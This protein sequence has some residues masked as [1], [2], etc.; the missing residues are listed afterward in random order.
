MSEQQLLEHCRT[1]YDEHG[2][3]ALTYTFMKGQPGLYMALYQLGLT[4]KVLAARLGVAEELKRHTTARPI[5]RAG[6]AMVRRSWPQIVEEAREVA[7]AHGSL[8]PAQWFQQNGRGSLVQY[9]YSSGHTW[10]ALREAAGDTSSGAFVQSRNGLRWRS[11]PEA[12]LSNFL[13]SRGV[14]HRRGDRY[15]KEYEA[16]SGKTHGR[17]DLHFKSL[18]GWI[19]VEVW[20]DDP[21]GHDPAKYQAVRYFKEQF[22]ASNPNFLGLHFERCFSG[23]GLSAALKPYI[24][25]IAPSQFD[26]STDPLIPTTHWS[27][28][29]EL[30]EHCRT[31]AAEM[32]GGAFPTD[33]WLRKRGKWADRPGPAYN[34]LSIY[35]ENWLGGIRAL[36][37]L[38]GQAHL[39]TTRWDRERVL[40]VWARFYQEHNR[41]PN[42][43]RAHHARGIGTF[44]PETV[45]LAGRL[46]NAVVKHV[47]GAAA[48]NQALGII[49]DRKRKRVARS[50]RSAAR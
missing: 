3:V 42:Q 6:R 48:A 11:H 30:L 26:N 15:P 23:E 22:N 31:L 44:T 46:V 47:G 2:P 13:Y 43:V 34:T 45:E 14:E 5:T 4:Q 25:I 40:I 8:P 38:L 41:T 37:A 39:S 32:P 36:R 9:V 21:G 19:D 28:T 24:G 16:L 12:S 1:L 17:Y 18:R 10:D 7:A 33:E 50:S 29:D 35:I 20:G 27:N 49:V